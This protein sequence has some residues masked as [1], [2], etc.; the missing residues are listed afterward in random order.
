[1]S[2]SKT[3]FR[4]LEKY[5]LVEWL[6]SFLL[7]V[8]T[9][10]P[11]L[12][13]DHV[14]FDG[15]EAM[16]GFMASDLISG[17][18][19]PVYFYG[20]RYGFSFFETIAAAVFIPLLG[21][22]VWSLK[23]GGMLLFSL[24]IQRLL[25]AARRNHIS[26]SSYLMLAIILAS[27]PA[28]LVWG[29]KLRGGYIT[30]F[31]AVAF[32]FEH[33]TSKPNWNWKNWSFAAFLTALGAVAQPLFLLPILPLLATRIAKMQPKDF[34]ALTLAGTCS[35]IILRLPALLNSNYWQPWN[36]YQYSI[37][38]LN[39][40]LI[41]GFWQSFTGY[42]S[43]TDVFHLPEYLV[44]LSAAYLII[45]ALL[46]LG[47]LRNSRKF[48]IESLLILSGTII[49]TFSV[50]FAAGGC[51]YL[52]AFH[53]GLVLILTLSVVR[54]EQEPKQLRTILMALLVLVSLCI[55]WQTKYTPNSPLMPEIND[56]RS[57]ESL[58]TRIRQSEIEHG[59]VS[60]WYLNWQLNYLLYDEVCFRH[61]YQ[62]DRV[63]KVIHQ[64]DQCYL[65]QDCKVLVTGDL[66]SKGSTGETDSWN[67]LEQQIGRYYL[68]A[69]P[70]DSFLFDLG[71]ELPDKTQ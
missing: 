26:F 34:L 56:M 30:A 31:V 7:V 68:I 28:W 39:K 35:Y 41:N 22:T 9:R 15:D 19:I 64:V 49:S 17:K 16:L 70:P 59:F 33:L 50:M 53:V 54:R 44:V 24:G 6:L 57:M 61:Y 2:T 3:I 65:N 20:Q 62:V 18:N 32:L 42:Y 48:R 13:G 11:Y 10:L 23:F 67:E 58:A 5:F 51:R 8:L 36:Y 71:F 29:T 69:N 14:Y 37:E 45:T 47:S 12:L 38:N 25:Q 60:N 63:E 21:N 66:W 52:L 43:Y 4:T 55:G 46:T 1:M 27:F 40:Y